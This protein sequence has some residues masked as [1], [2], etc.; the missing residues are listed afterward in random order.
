MAQ[1]AKI[2][3][4]SGKTLIRI[5][6]F[7][8]IFLVTE[9]V[10]CLNCQ[11]STTCVFYL[12]MKPLAVEP[13]IAKLHL[14][15]V[16]FVP[17]FSLDCHQCISC[18][19]VNTIGKFAMKNVLNVI[20]FS[21]ASQLQ[22]MNPSWS[23]D[24]VFQEARKIVGAEIQVILYTEFLPKILGSTMDRVLGVYKGYD[25]SVDST[26]SNVFTTSAYRFG[27]GMIMEK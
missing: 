3:T 11:F 1:A 14:L 23:G 6:K 16:I 19:L 27:H 4:N 10:E 8:Y 22:Q 26:V 21:V 13:Q 18:L 7:F 24:R 20:C 12:S 15:P 17:I 2:C 9:E 25:S 5:L